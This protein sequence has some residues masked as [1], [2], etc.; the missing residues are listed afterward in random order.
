MVEALDDTD[1][2]IVDVLSVDGR[3]SM[4]ALAEQLHVSRANVYAR[5]ERLE[6][7]GVIR[8]Y[9]ADVDPVAAG[10][11]TSA[12]VTLSL[13]Q[14]RWREVRDQLSRVPGVA[15]IALLG[16][17]FDVLLLLRARD[18][19]DLRRIILDEIQRMEGVRGTQTFLVF[20]ETES[21]VTLGG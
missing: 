16:G 14:Q 1:R 21:A 20:E 13:E 19:A 9:R 18:N 17:Q 6:R 5:V 15:H 10:L 7:S 2:R 4:R 3:L 11:K 8:G 12:Y